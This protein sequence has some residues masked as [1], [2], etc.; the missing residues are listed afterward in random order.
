MSHVLLLPA[1]PV[2]HSVGTQMDMDIVSAVAT[3]KMVAKEILWK[4]IL[5]NIYLGEVLPRKP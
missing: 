3:T 1:A 5:T 2:M 4:I